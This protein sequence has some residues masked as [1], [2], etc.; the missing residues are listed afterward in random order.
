METM[1]G[2]KNT[3]GLVEKFIQRIEVDFRC[4]SLQAA[5]QHK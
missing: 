1:K 5:T 3:Y 4:Q 2:G